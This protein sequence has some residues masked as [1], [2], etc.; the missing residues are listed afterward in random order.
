MTVF[1][2]F[3][4][5][6]GDHVDVLRLLLRAGAE[7]DAVTRSGGW[8]PLHLACRYTS[9][10]CVVEL[11]RWNAS[12]GPAER[13]SSFTARA[14]GSAVHSPDNNE[15]KPI[16]GVA[17]EDYP[18]EEEE[19]EENGY[20]KTPAEVVGLKILAAASTGPACSGGSGHRADPSLD[21]EEEQ[22]VVFGDDDGEKSPALATQA[23]PI[24]SAP[25]SNAAPK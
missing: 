17:L 25:S 16:F 12:L 20:G 15:T 9:V 5:V 4:A 7:R 18:P 14:E 11:L 8:T 2:L 23:P 24:C 19:E 1:E 6:Q 13:P 3:S 22:M 21:E 10:E